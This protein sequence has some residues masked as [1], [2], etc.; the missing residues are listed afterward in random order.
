MALSA[1]RTTLGA[2]VKDKVDMSASPEVARDQL[3]DAALA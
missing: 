3:A 2:D 1:D